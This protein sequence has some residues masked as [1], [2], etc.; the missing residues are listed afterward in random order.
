MLQQRL[1]LLNS[2]LKGDGGDISSFFKEGRL[3]VVDLSDPFVDG[4]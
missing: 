1:S 3:V 2:F 4:E